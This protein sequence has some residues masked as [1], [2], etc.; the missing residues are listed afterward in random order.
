MGALGGADLGD[1][2]LIYFGELIQDSAGAGR[3]RCGLGVRRDMEFYDHP[4]SFSTLSER[5]KF[6]PKGLFDGDDADTARYCVNPDGDQTQEL[7]S[8]ETASL[9]PN[10]IVSV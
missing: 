10:D 8:K 9:D 7:R 1:R 3:T 4:A 5:A 6:P 2:D